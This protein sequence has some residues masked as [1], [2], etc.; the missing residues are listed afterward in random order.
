[1]CL[2]PVLHNKDGPLQ[3]EARPPQQRVAPHSPQLEKARAQQ[4]RPDAAKNKY[5]F[6]K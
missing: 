2:E 6:K 5:I 4:R 1:M 3:Q